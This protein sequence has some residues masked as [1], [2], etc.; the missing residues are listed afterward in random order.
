MQ[1]QTS[2]PTDLLF[3]TIDRSLHN[4]TRKDKHM[5]TSLHHKSSVARLYSYIYISTS[6]AVTTLDLNAG[7][8]YDGLFICGGRA[9]QN[10]IFQYFSQ[11]PYITIFVY[12]QRTSRQ[13]IM[14][15]VH[16][17]TNSIL[18]HQAAISSRLI[19]V[20]ALGLI[21]RVLSKSRNPAL[22]NI[23]LFFTLST[24]LPAIFQRLN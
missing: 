15:F 19:V 11:C 5:N 9:L 17:I 12:I 4:W 16:I 8:A 24:I 7:A 6:H 21:L 20:A 22:R 23:S 3:R 18:E 2:F 10:S 14:S 1:M 13:N